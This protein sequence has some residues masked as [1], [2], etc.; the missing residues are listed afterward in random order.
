MSAVAGML[1]GSWLIGNF[2]FCSI[3]WVIN[4]ILGF[5]LCFNHSGV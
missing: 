3:A 1:L 4:G 2:A 5:E